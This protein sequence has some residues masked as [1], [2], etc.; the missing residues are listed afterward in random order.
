[1]FRRLKERMDRNE[2]EFIRSANQ[3]E[4]MMRKLDQLIGRKPRLSGLQNIQRQNRAWDRALRTML[5][6]PPMRQTTLAK[7]SKRPKKQQPAGCCGCGAAAVVG[8]L[9]IGGLALLSI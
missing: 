7:P 3:Q 6:G 2:R 9:L 5:T 4:R 1:M 8:I